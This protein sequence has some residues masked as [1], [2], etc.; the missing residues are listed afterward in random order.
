MKKYI[1]A[2]VFCVSLFVLSPAAEPIAWIDVSSPFAA[3]VGVPMMT[4]DAA[5]LTTASTALLNGTGIANGAAATA[6]FRYSTAN[7]GTCSDSFGTRAP[8][9]GGAALGAGT[10]PVAFSQSISGLSVG[11]TYYV[12]AIAQNSFGLGFGVVQSFSAG[13]A[14]TVF[15]NP[16]SS[17]T[18]SS[19]QLNGAVNPNGVGTTA[20]FRYSTVSPVTCNDTFGT[21]APT[22]GGFSFGEENMLFSIP[23]LIS[24]LPFGTTFYYC[25]IAENIVGKTYG[26]LRTFTTLGGSPDVTTTG[27][28]QVTTTSATLNATANPRAFATTAWLRY[29][30]FNPGPCN[31]A[32]GTRLPAS[33][34]TALGSGNAEVSFSQPVTGLSPNTTYY[35]CGIAENSAGISFGSVVP[36]T[37][38]G[39]PPSFVT[40]S[41]ATLVTI[42]SATL[43]G[44]ALPN[45][46]AT[47]AWFR[48]SSVNPGTCSDTFGTR[49]PASGG[50]ALGTGTQP[51][52]YSQSITG[53]TL[54]TTYFYCAIAQNSLGTAFGTV[55]MLT[56][57]GGPPIVTT[58][59]QTLVTTTSATLNGTANPNNLATTAWFRY[60][61]VNPGT[62]NDTFGTRAPAAGGTALGSG[63]V[64]IS[65]GQGISGLSIGATYYYCA[66]AQ[67]SQGTS[68][69][70]I[71]S[72][73]T[74]GGPPSV[75]TGEATQVTA[76]S[77]TL[78]AAANPNGVDTTAWFRYSTV[79]PG[80]CNDTFGTRAPVSGGSAVGTGMLP[81]S[82]SQ[83]IGSLTFGTVYYYCGIAQNSQGIS[84]GTVKTFAPGN[85]SL[86]VLIVYADSNLPF[87]LA[88]SI[89][90]QPEVVLLDYF[91][92]GAN[93]PTPAQLHQYDIVVT[94]AD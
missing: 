75:E 79:D 50:S 12:C 40:T 72:F 68:F 69:G 86:Q 82:Y 51:V 7:P 30:T 74:A 45:S 52:A 13:S 9:S 53:L 41:A 64:P 38:L 23:Q 16:A 61:S 67:N 27:P 71:V 55:Q 26:A 88:G 8:S 63:A 32:F 34:G 48:Y 2:A 20:W 6:W 10:A 59:T 39:R 84:F 29:S 93:T 92:A 37:T 24:G 73:T 42:N 91:D 70:G 46:L 77:A 25:A 85:C 81:V 5:S 43:N 54:G 94:V 21:R 66:I 65:Y 44:S 49:A 36:F 90:A 62:C 35:F 60:S 47:T 76:N 1:A 4:T 17:F 3:M 56:T 31:D 57:L 33:G 83:P 58:D 78:N 19:A 22:S 15:T 89:Q 14:P 80:T 87:Q 18:T 11:V 28:S